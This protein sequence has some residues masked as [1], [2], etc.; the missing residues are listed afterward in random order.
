MPQ[1]GQDGCVG[2]ERRTRFVDI[3]R[4]NPPKTVCPNFYVLSHANGCAFDPQCE[5]CYL[6]SS[7]WYLKDQEVFT[8][9]DDMIDEV[10]RW[11]RLDGLES[12][13]LNS[14]NLSDSLA[15]ETMRPAISRL[16]ELFREEAQA[17]GRPHALL[18][19]TKGGPDECM[20]LFEVAPCANV[21]VSF[22]IN[23]AQAAKRYESGAAST[24]ERFEAAARLKGHGWRVRIRIDPMILPYDYTQVIEET[25]QLEPERVTLGTL[26]AEP[27]LFKRVNHGM[28]DR[29]VPG[30]DPKALARYP[31]EDRIALYRQAVARLRDI[32][33]IG[34][35]EESEEVWRACGLDVEGKTCNCGS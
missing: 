4:T 33:P 28:F 9:V 3:F 19:V 10:R 12:Y 15:F 30:D 8:N 1:G 34:L 2:R 20:P 16:V 6:K 24:F 22:S 31:E 14:G 18:I 35:C 21:I 13:V 26:R 7:F 27:S 25:R 32:C 29:L 11:I 23:N 17:E 5:Y